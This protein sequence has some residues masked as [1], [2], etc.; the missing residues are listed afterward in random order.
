MHLGPVTKAGS[1]VEC[2][3]LVARVDVVKGG[4]PRRAAAT[5]LLQAARAWA[6]GRAWGVA[7]KW[8]NTNCV[9]WWMV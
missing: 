3:R 5:R 7:R 1:R 9:G 4:K 8:E 6:A 2:M